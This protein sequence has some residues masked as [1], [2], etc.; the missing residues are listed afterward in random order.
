MLE[1]GRI[2]VNRL[3]TKEFKLEEGTKAFEFAS[4][5]TVTKVIINI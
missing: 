1:K 2:E 5:P 3:I 4:Q